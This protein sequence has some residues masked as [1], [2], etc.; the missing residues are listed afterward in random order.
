MCK[1]RPSNVDGVA[2]KY[3]KNYIDF[4]LKLNQTGK[5]KAAFSA[6]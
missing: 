3:W 6:G 5:I 1:T 2:T 4:N